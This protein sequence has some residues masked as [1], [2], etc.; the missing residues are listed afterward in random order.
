MNKRIVVEISGRTIVFVVVFLLLLKFLWLVKDILFSLFIAFIFR[1]ALLPL[2]I[3]LRRLKIPH[4]LAA[5]VVFLLFL[6]ALAGFFYLIFPPLAIELTSFLRSTPYYLEVFTPKFESIVQ[7]D[8]LHQYIPNVTSFVFGVVGGLFS[9][10]FFIFVTLF[11]TLYFLVQENFVRDLLTNFVEEDRIVWAVNLIKKIERRMAAWLWGELVLMVIIGLATFIG[12]SVLK[13]KYALSLAVIAG[14]L[15][16]VPNIGPIIA[17]VP[18]FLIGISQSL[19]T[20][21]S[22]V[23]LY[24]IIQQFENTLIVP[25]VMKK[26][27]GLNP[28]VT[29]LALL[30]GGKIGGVV[31]VLLA[32]PFTLFLE[33]LI[34][35]LL[36]GR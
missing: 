11:F 1:S 12:L 18:A 14:I 2:V 34:I 17:T 21:V 29:L 36:K 30:I 35:E 10:A 19:V 13:V 8:N 28:I 20:G 15:E 22:V 24:F 6:G 9:N 4:S 31:G 16:I 33:T 25:L 3:R 5:G 26:A 32:I 27:V 23:A 7:L